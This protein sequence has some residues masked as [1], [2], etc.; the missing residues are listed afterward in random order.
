MYKAVN[1]E[2]LLYLHVTDRL[3]RR[4]EAASNYNLRNS[5]NFE[6]PFTRLCSFETSFFPST[7]ILRN[8]L[9]NSTWNTILV[10]KF[11]RSLR[12][13][14]CKPHAFM[15]K[16]HRMPDVSLTRLRHTCS[17]LN[18]EL[19]QVIIVNNYTAVEDA[20]CFFFECP[21]YHDQRNRLNASLIFF[22]NIDLNMLLN[23]HPSFDN[24]INSS[25]L[26]TVLKYIKDTYR[27]T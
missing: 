7:I 18:G 26:E 9:D 8:I 14:P 23:G 22:P 1:N 5:Q 17:S 12:Q 24:N 20:L 2:A 25:I 10:L 27:F 13:P 11:K 3:P 6:I 15:T 4:V 16:Q 21:L 19:F